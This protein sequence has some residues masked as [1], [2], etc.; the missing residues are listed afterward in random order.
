MSIPP[1]LCIY[2][3]GCADGFAAAWAVRRYMHQQQAAGFGAQATGEPVDFHPGI[4]G[5][6]PPDVTGRSVIIVDFSYPRSDM[7]R[8]AEQAHSILVIDH[9]QTA[10]Q[11]LC[12]LPANMRTVFDMHH[13]GAVLTWQQ[14]F[15]GEMPP[16]LFDHIQDRDLWL[17]RLPMTR[18]IVAALFSYPMD[19]AAWD[20][21]MQR[22]IRDLETEGRSILRQQRQHV[23]ALLDNL[24]RWVHFGDAP[25][26]AANVPW[27]YA[28]E[29]AGRL[30]DGNPFAAAYQD[31]DEGRK[32]SL[33]SGPDGADVAAIAEALGGGGH[34]HAAGFRMTRHEVAE[35]E[36]KGGRL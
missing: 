19:F 26:P 10:A 11:Q 18:E 20:A 17:F 28:S 29:V 5:E 27:F 8:M 4:Y 24:T 30:A 7:L 6:P 9:H 31:D 35:F 33:R 14:L 3:H 16:V 12:D 23:D 2:H 36:A 22:P 1:T 13:S 32:W 25:V 21:L 34:R 15:P